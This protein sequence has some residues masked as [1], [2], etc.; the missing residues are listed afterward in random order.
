MYDRSDYC[1]LFFLL[2]ENGSCRSPQKR[3]RKQDFVCPIFPFFSSLCT[4]TLLFSII[5]L[6]GDRANHRFFIFYFSSEASCLYSFSLKRERKEKRIKE[7][8]VKR[9]EKIR[10][11]LPTASSWEDYL[12]R[13]NEKRRKRKMKAFVIFNNAFSFFS[14]FLIPT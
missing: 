2:K 8:S 7:A 10:I 9:K 11:G 4:G 12:G 1:F 14:L 13:W 3:R 6:L 5:L